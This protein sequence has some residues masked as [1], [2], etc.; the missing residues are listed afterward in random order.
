M[1][2]LQPQDLEKKARELADKEKVLNAREDLVSRENAL[3]KRQKVFDEAEAKIDVL[4]KQIKAKEDIIAS[5]TID[6]DTFVTS[7]NERIESLKVREETVKNA[8]SERQ[9]TLADIKT[10]ETN[11]SLS[12]KQRKNELAEV[13][14]QIKEALH[15]KEEQEKLVENTIAEWNSILVEFRK[16]ADLIQDEKNKLSS[17]IIRLEQDKS[18]LAID[19][20]K[21]QSRLE[22]L[23]EAY[24][25]KADEYKA[26]LRIL[27]TDISAKRNELGS[28]INATDMRVKEVETR[29]KSVK[30]KEGNLTRRASE[31][32]QKERRLKMNYGIA[33]IAWQDGV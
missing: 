18:A 15:Y 32:D 6:F 27:D 10:Q 13:K 8:I 11:V 23:Y 30:L 9:K 7:A 14:E 31:L 2:S 4:T 1:S 26:K 22:S 3:N 25:L 17:D 12:I 5:R 16:E 33:D 20:N 24:E 28:V 19:M 21:E 29:E